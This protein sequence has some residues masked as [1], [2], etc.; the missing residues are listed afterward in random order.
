[1][2]SLDT[3]DSTNLPLS[4]FNLIHFGDAIGAT[5]EILLTMICVYL[6]KYKP[7]ILE[8]MDTKKQSINAVIETLAFHCTTDLERATVL[9][10][11]NCLLN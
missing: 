1:M 10:K 4:I 11:L 7:S 6:N 5:D 3:S 2:K 8:T 9:H